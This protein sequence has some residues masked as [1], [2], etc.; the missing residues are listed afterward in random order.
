MQSPI[1]ASVSEWTSRTPL[2]SSRRRARSEARCPWKAVSEVISL[3][4]RSSVSAV[5]RARLQRQ[6]RFDADFR[7]T[8]LLPHRVID[9][10]LAM[11]ESVI[12]T[13]DGVVATL[14]LNRPDA[15]NVL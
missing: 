8:R 12:L 2:T 15:L 4:S 14:T 5:L 7:S 10:C 3:G 13:R 11:N 1:F 6:R 9:A